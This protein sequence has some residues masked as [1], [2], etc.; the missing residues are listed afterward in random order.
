VINA[1]FAAGPWWPPALSLHAQAFV[2]IAYGA[3]L[4]ATL[5]WAL[6]HGRRFFQSER[7]G[8]YAESSP[9]GDRV[10]SPI[11]YPL[12]MGT[13]LVCAL[14]L[15]LNRGVLWAALIN[16]VLC[17]HYF[18]RLRWR[19]ALR[20]MG[21]PGFMTYWLGAA[22]LL[23]E[24][25]TRLTPSARP[26]A[27]V[28]LQVDL[29]VIMLS[30]GTYKLAAGFAQN[31]GMELGL[32]NPAW[33]YWW[34]RYAALPPSHW[35]LWTLNQLA[36]STEVT[37]AIL[38]LVPP[39]RTIG[40]LLLIASFFF[41]ATQI[42]LALLCEMVMTCGVLYFAPGTAPDRVV[43]AIAARVGAIPPLGASSFPTL[44]HAVT[45]VLW[46]YV[47]LLPIAHG[48]LFYNLY[49]RR[50]LPGRWQRALE[51]YTNVFGMI[52]WR[53]FS[54]DLVNFYIRIHRQHRATGER[55]LLSRYGL[56]GGLRFSHVAESITVTCV[57]TTLKY[58]A[59]NADL[60]EQRLRRYVRTLPVDADHLIVLEY[61]SLLKIPS[62]FES[63]PVA[64]YVVD[65]IA[66]T[67][68][69]LVLRPD[70]S[71]HA[72]HAGSP[73]REGVTPGSYVPLEPALGDRSARPIR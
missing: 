58:Y 5:L 46:A 47:L 16:L 8:G 59:T 62:C 32:A 50:S 61:V 39:T 6:P 14:L 23:L 57:F 24:G 54:A 72:A 53:V 29:A 64:E 21:A 66:G 43:G 10:H 13:W 28:A 63:V 27:L 42:R 7:W 69:R 71:V 70:V 15:M 36:W 2:R 22:V 73:L 1:F 33:G 12:V 68:S 55:E 17:R 11:A 26:M 31:E 35:L 40:G 3:L 56:G 45:I 4:L 25:T 9:W 60:F 52:V 41:I 18:I 37:A 38:M 49:A 48:G 65:P 51:R 34:R 20:G 44:E 67:I 19:G 30:A